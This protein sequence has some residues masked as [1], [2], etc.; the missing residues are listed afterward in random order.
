MHDQ[1]Y[2]LVAARGTGSLQPSKAHLESELSEKRV[3]A[4]L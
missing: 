2:S 3:K 4:P 1:E